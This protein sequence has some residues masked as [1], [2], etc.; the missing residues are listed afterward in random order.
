MMFCSSRIKKL[1]IIAAIIII[2]IALVKVCY[3][4]E[5]GFASTTPITDKNIH[6]A[7]NAWIF[8]TESAT[9]TYGHI[10]DWDTSA[11][12]NMADLFSAYING[13]TDNKKKFFNDN[14]SG[15]NVSQVRN[16][17]SMFNNAQ[18]FNQDISGWDVSNVTNMEGMF[19][20]AFKINQDISGWDVSKVTNM[21]YMFF[22]AWDFNQDIRGWD[23]SKVTK[24]NGMFDIATKMIQNQEAPANPTQAYFNKAA[25]A[26]DSF[27]RE[28]AKTH[29]LPDTSHRG[30]EK[31]YLADKIYIHPTLRENIEKNN[32]TDNGEPDWEAINKIWEGIME[33]PNSDAARTRLLQIAEKNGVKEKDLGLYAKQDFIEQYAMRSY[34][35]PVDFEN[36]MPTEN[37]NK[38]QNEMYMDILDNSTSVEEAKQKYE[39][40]A[41]EYPPIDFSAE[42]HHHQVKDSGFCAKDPN[43]PT[44][45]LAKTTDTEGWGKGDTCYKQGGGTTGYGE[46]QCVGGTELSGCIEACD[47]EDIACQG[48]TS[49]INANF[50]CSEKVCDT[51]YNYRFTE[52]FTVRTFEGRVILLVEEM[53]PKIIQTLR[54]QGKV[55][56]IIL[57]EIVH[58]WMFEIKMNGTYTKF[59]PLMRC[60][61]DYGQDHRG[62]ETIEI[63]TFP[64]SKFSDGRVDTQ[65]IS[66]YQ[67]GG[68]KSLS[69][70]EQEAK[71]RADEEAAAKAKADA[72]AAAKIKGNAASE[73]AGGTF[74]PHDQV[75]SILDENDSPFEKLVDNNTV[76]DPPGIMGPSSL[77]P[78]DSRPVNIIITSNVGPYGLVT[79]PRKPQE[80]SYSHELGDKTNTQVNKTMSFMEHVM[81]TSQQ[82]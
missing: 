62:K 49:E 19:N 53:K 78:P 37:S 18:V 7:V 20:N 40:Y 43:N 51:G 29:F 52:N 30:S 59:S 73:P 27:T 31:N 32:R 10:K 4:C 23:V 68:P 33:Q 79:N 69:R 80:I 34:E 35:L 60:N 3:V 66:W 47:K 42:E 72:E 17:R 13:N 8:D 24:F 46:G 63:K 82:R 81:N 6:D 25:S 44:Y 64:P 22:Q 21:S 15:W 76:I 45:Y 70:E 14:I 5:E 75:G 38:K 67:C 54:D 9:A 71:E 58:N 74:A 1:G 48:V 56:D 36:G 39:K 2:I 61:H 77:T 16:M 41:K 50:E 26:S 28:E 11:V 55:P 57:K 65:S 12:T